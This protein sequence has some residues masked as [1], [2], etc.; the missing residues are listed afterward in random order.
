MFN[1][2]YYAF[3]VE[4]F[5]RRLSHRYFSIWS[6]KIEL[7]FI[8][9]NYCFPKS[10]DLFSMSFAYFNSFPQLTLLTNGF[11][12]ATRPNNPASCTLFGIVLTFSEIRSSDSISVLTLWADKRRLDLIL[13]TIN[14]SVA[15]VVFLLRTRPNTLPMHL[16]SLYFRTMYRIVSRGSNTFEDT[17]RWESPF[18]WCLTIKLR[19]CLLWSFFLGAIKIKCEKNGKFTSIYTIPER[20]TSTFY[21]FLD[22]ST[23]K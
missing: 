4:L 12:S 5:L 21:K 8:G 1:C 22:H 7:W 16:V 15:S 11:F 14:R 9:P 18:W 2:W 17:S 10:T 3:G 19:R 6:E 13:H 20:P 23:E